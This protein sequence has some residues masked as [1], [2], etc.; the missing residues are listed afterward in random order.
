MWLFVIIWMTL[1][2]AMLSARI[3]QPAA[4]LSYSESRPSPR[5]CQQLSF[6]NTIL[7][8]W[9]EPLGSIIG[10]LLSDV[11]GHDGVPDARCC[12]AWR[13]GIT[14]ITAVTA[15][16]AIFHHSFEK[17]QVPPPFW[18]TIGGGVAHGPPLVKSK[19]SVMSGMAASR[20]VS[21]GSPNRVSMN[22]STAV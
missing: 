4:L 19:N 16:S 15:I 6:V 17:S 11:A 5:H 2:P 8:S 14:A 18:E 12:C 22:F 13:G 21:A 20:L 7:S 9:I 10:K 1:R 3:P